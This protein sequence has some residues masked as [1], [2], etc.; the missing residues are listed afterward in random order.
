MT[1]GVLLFAYN[2]EQIDYVAQACFLAKRIKQYMNLPTSL[3]TDDKERV[4]KFYNGAEVFDEIIT[5]DI[6]RKNKKT[7]HDGSLSKKVLDFKNFNRSDAYDLTPYDKTLIMDT[8]YII[9]NSL[10]V[11]CFDSANDLMMY[12]TCMDISG[13]R[14]EDEFRYI[15]ETSIKFY[16]ATCVYF[17]KN[18]RNKA[19]F[20]FVKHI[21]ENYQHYRNLYQITSTVFRNDYAFSI[22]AHVLGHV[23]ELPG[24]MIY[25]THKDILQNIHNDEIK[26][27]VEKYDRVGEYTLLKSNGLNVHVMNKF[28][29]NREMINA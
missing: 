21:K 2:N 4:L 26:L 29:L 9:S 15:S 10:L 7:Y 27:L 8:D 12:S 11:N 18:K 3:V 5:S 6:I 19:F 14:D 28:S 24:T 22:A 23:K 16:W 25:S 1:S 13:W 20:D 17:T